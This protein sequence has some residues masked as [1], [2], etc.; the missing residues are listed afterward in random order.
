M[1]FFQILFVIVLA[2]A[3][4]NCSS[5]KMVDI[6]AARDNS[7][8]ARGESPKNGDYYKRE[9]EL[10]KKVI[11]ER[12]PDV[13]EQGRYEVILRN[14]SYRNVK[15]KVYKTSFWRDVEW[16]GAALMGHRE[17]RKRLPV[18]KYLVVVYYNGQADARQV[19]EISTAE[20]YD[21]KSG[22]YV[23]KVIEY[24]F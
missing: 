11:R 23:A 21:S 6:D 7:E 24:N 4:N 20:E 8:I 5:L 10:A 18:G 12:S 1:R 14:N 19:Y 17:T 16:F 22:E 15:I 3:L 2:F 13:D 9:Q